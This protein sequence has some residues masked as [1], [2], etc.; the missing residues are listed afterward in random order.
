MC[1]PEAPG[2]QTCGDSID[3]KDDI[4]DRV[5]GKSCDNPVQFT[6]QTIKQLPNESQVPDTNCCI[7]HL[8]VMPDDLTTVLS[9]HTHAYHSDDENTSHF[10]LKRSSKI[11][12]MIRL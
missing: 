3:D 11:S 6:F 10:R 8:P 12:R 7:V 2:I 4:S 9:S 1:T 5:S